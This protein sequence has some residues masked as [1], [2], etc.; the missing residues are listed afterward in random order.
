MRYI[1]KLPDVEELHKEYS[2]T[3]KEKQN[4]MQAINTIQNIL[5]GKDKRKLIIVGPCSADR[6]DSVM[7]YITRLAGLAEKVSDKLFIVPR[8]YTGKPRT[9]GEGYKGMLHNPYGDNDEDLLKGI[10]AARRLHLRVIREAGLYSADEML[11]PDEMYYMSDLLSYLAVGARSVEDQGHRMVASDDSIPVGLKNPIGGSKISLINSIKAAQ[12]PH[13]LIYRGWEVETDGNLYAHA[14]LRG[15]TNK[16]GKNYPNYHYEDLIELHD[17]SYKNS[18]TNVGVIV[19][20]NH[21]NSN[22]KYD[23]QP[24]IAK[25]VFGFCAQNASINDFVKGLMIESYIEDGCQIVGQGIYGKSIT[26]PC[27][28]WNKTYALLCDLAEHVK[29]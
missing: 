19:D 22:K 21:S 25:E 4:R 6:E 29:M 8:V 13:R 7:E 23:E 20:C 28:G 10:V 26:D 15:F 5:A 1:K 27:L 9:T 2:L 24:R 12:S 14:I 11:Y 18:L 3:D 16:S 17:M